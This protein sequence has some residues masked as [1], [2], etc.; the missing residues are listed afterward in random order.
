MA[1]S[2]NSQARF[3]AK[4]G[5]DGND[6]SMVRIGIKQTTAFVKHP[7][8]V[9]IPTFQGAVTQAFNLITAG[10]PAILTL[11]LLRGFCQSKSALSPLA[12]GEV[13]LRMFNCADRRSMGYLS[14]DDVCLACSGRFKWRRYASLWRAVVCEAVRLCNHGIPSS[15]MPPVF[16]P[17]PKLLARDVFEGSNMLPNSRGIT[18]SKRLCQR[19]ASP[20]A[21]AGAMTQCVTTS[22]YDLEIRLTISAQLYPLILQALFFSWGALAAAHLPCHGVARLQRQVRN[23]R[24]AVIAPIFSVSVSGGKL[25]FTV[26][27]NEKT[28]EGLQIAALDTRPISRAASARDSRDVDSARPVTSRQ[29]ARYGI[30]HAR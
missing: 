20:T 1:S 25:S 28:R 6:I 12:K 30:M 29:N 2:L 4:H 9:L 11:P 21:R 7:G 15:V 8:F 10:S 13:L 18:L 16:E 23:N 17:T 5:V 14:E 19:S 22:T 3:L 26:V 27:D 24:V